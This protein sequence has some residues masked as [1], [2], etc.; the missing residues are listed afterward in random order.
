[1]QRATRFGVLGGAKPHA[2]PPGRVRLQVPKVWTTAPSLRRDF[3]DQHSMAPSRAFAPSMAL[4]RALSRPQPLRCPFARPIATPFIRGK[5]TKT[6]KRLTDLQLVE[7]MGEEALKAWDADDSWMDRVATD[8]ECE[9]E[10][11]PVVS[12]YEQDLDKGTPRVLISRMA[13]AEDRKKNRDMLLML[14]EWARNPDYDDTEL[15]RLTIDNLLENPTLSHLTEELKNIKENMPTWAE[16]REMEQWVRDIEAEA[17]PDSEQH[18]IKMRGRFREAYEQLL[19]DPDAAIAKEELREVLDRMPEE[20]E[21]MKTPE[22]QA[23]VDRA[24]GKLN[25]DPE[26]PEKWAKKLEY[27]EEQA[28]AARKKLEETESEIQAAAEYLEAMDTVPE[29]VDPKKFRDLDPLLLQMRDVLKA[30]GTDSGL[31]A[32]MDAILAEDPTAKQDNDIDRWMD[33]DEFAQLGEDMLKQAKAKAAQAQNEEVVPADL[34]YKI[35]KIMEDPKLIEKLAYLQKIIE[36][37]KRKNSDKTKHAKSVITTI[38]H[39]VGPDP[40]E[41]EDSC[42]VTLKQRI[43]AAHEDPEHSAALDRIR[44]NLSA[45]FH[46]SPALKSFNQAIELAYI[47]A[48]DDIRRVLWRCYLKARTLPTFLQNVS[49]EAWDIIY[50]SQAVTW[51][52]NQN[53]QD[54]LETILADLK[55]LGRNGPPTHPSSLAKSG[56]E[57][58]L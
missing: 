42:T 14:E 58:H 38:A 6:A 33:Q 56:A 24:W 41:L 37:H 18:K 45:P 47:G 32:E 46:I 39:E 57:Q 55:S 27:V 49:D 9:A 36:E 8:E 34:Q 52:S 7:K 11:M 12:W 5:R 44:V 28:A 3:H 25:S 40:Y 23:I 17:D 1:V 22:F 15:N 53:R 51:P 19:N 16:R 13:T 2:A 48:N 50:Y 54:H 29:G 10:D 4:I 43:Q 31:A 20:L 30:M 21:G 35:D 26:W